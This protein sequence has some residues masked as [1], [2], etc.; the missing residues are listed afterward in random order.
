MDNNNLLSQNGEYSSDT[1]K[2]KSNSDAKLNDSDDIFEEASNN[3]NT[4]SET[5]QSNERHPT[6]Q[7]KS[8]KS[9]KILDLFDLCFFLKINLGLIVNIMI[10]NVLQLKNQ[11]KL[12][13][14]WKILLLIMMKKS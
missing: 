9:M 3:L 8:G 7:F 4:L 12:K 1:E 14:K 11:M 10:W 2:L 13:K 5:N 6:C